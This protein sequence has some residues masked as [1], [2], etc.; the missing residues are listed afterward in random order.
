MGRF[1]DFW[2]KMTRDRA[3]DEIAKQL[4]R[5]LRTVTDGRAADQLVCDASDTRPPTIE[6]CRAMS[7]VLLSLTERQRAVMALRHKG[8]HPPDIAAHLG[9]T[10]ELAKRELSAGLMA[11]HRARLG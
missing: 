1:A 2:T 7:D 6:E 9:I 4:Y 11:L 5:E 10:V 3:A 8:M